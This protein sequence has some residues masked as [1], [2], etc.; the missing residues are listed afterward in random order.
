[1]KITE[2]KNEDALELLCDLLDPMTKILSDKE[3]LEAMKDG[4]SKIEIVKTAIKNNK[5][6]V[7]EVL[8]R[9]KGVPVKDY[10]ENLISMIAEIF[11][12]LND[13]ELLSFFSSLGLNKVEKSSTN[14]TEITKAKKK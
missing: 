2:Y 5:S 1:M 7:I 6:S 9:L 10:N 8:A 13:E 3:L 12:I 14:V 11:T 4:A